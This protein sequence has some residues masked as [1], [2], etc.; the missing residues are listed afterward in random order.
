MDVCI[1]NR[2]NFICVL[3]LYGELVS[4]P[5]LPLDEELVRGVG[6]GLQQGPAVDDGQQRLQRVQEQTDQS[7]APALVT[8]KLHRLVQDRYQSVAQDR[9]VRY[10][11]RPP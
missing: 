1:M 9:P 8:A 3:P 4:G 5:R 10:G 6:V 7:R 2:R 11:Q